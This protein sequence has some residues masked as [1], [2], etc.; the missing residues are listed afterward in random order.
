[1]KPSAAFANPY[2]VLV[3]ASLF[4]GGNAIAGKLASLDWQPFTIT[5]TRWVLVAVLVLPFASEHIRKDWGTIKSNWK[6]LALLSA[7]SMALFNLLMYLALH[8]TSAINVSIEQASMPAMIMLANFLFLSQRITLLQLVGLVSSIVGVLVICTGGEVTS[9]LDQG[10]NRGDAYM[11]LAC[12]F[13]AAYTFGL[14]WK[15]DLHWLSF[16][17][18]LAIGASAMS[19]PWAAWEW[20]NTTFTM[21]GVTGWLVL[22]YIIIFP[23]IVSQIFYARGVQLIGGNRAGLFINLVPI[24]GSLLAILI[25]R[26]TFHYFHGVGL[27]MVVGGIMLA[28]RYAN[29]Q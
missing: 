6:I 13:Y 23:T 3:M 1:M 19:L 16:I 24:F 29:R 28:E 15:P 22:V 12:A 20:R 11:L 26:E 4:W 8:F 7:F 10:V 5:F 2:F 18:V 21:P 17:W 27:V 9:L 25:L 14:R